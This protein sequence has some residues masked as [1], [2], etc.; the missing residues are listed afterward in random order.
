MFVHTSTCKYP[1]IHTW[2]RSPVRLL[3][4]IA[5]SFFLLSGW[6]VALDFIS[7]RM[8]SHSLPTSHTLLNMERVL[9]ERENRSI[10]KFYPRFA[11]LIG[12]SEFSPSTQPS[13][14]SLTR[15]LSS[16]SLSDPAWLGVQEKAENP[17]TRRSQTQ[18]FKTFE[19]FISHLPSQESFIF[20]QNDSISLNA[21]KTFN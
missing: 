10:M 21:N 6:I 9:M 17:I 8:D 2:L 5:A 4:P 7:T 12:W 19:A 11:M 15:F 3:L 20:T 1:P 18:R 16:F 13:G 14:L